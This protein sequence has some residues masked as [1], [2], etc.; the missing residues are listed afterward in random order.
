VSGYHPLFIL[1]KCFKRLFQKPYIAKSFA[2]AYGYLSGYAKS[3]PRVGNKDLI[4]Y[5]RTQQMRRLRFLVAS[6]WK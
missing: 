5:I 3:M 6:N 4:H 2:H 1:L